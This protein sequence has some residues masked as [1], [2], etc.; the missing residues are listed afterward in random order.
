VGSSPSSADPS[1]SAQ[2]INNFLCVGSQSCR[3]RPLRLGYARKRYEELLAELYPELAGVRGLRLEVWM[4]RYRLGK[5]AWYPQDIV[6][7]LEREVSEA[8]VRSIA[9]SSKK[10][11]VRERLLVVQYAVGKY[12][13]RLAS[14]VYI[15]ST[16]SALYRRKALLM[17]AALDSSTIIPPGIEA[18]FLLKSLDQLASELS[19]RKTILVNPVIALKWIT[20]YSDYSREFA[21][22]FRWFPHTSWIMYRGE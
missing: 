15:V 21:S 5:G 10:F 20:Q 9:Q 12:R 13:L 6:A 19:R 11:R 7:R 22:R 8:L 16:P 14:L 18:E 3:G 4:Q 17:A 2:G 1:G